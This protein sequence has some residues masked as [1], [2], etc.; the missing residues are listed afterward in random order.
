MVY[1][2]TVSYADLPCQNSFDFC[3]ETGSVGGFGIFVR[4]DVVP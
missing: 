1:K 2:R 4:H 3:A